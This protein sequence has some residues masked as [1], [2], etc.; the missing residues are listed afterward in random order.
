[1][2]GAVKQWLAPLMGR[3]LGGGSGRPPMLPHR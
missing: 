1:M 2:G 3:M